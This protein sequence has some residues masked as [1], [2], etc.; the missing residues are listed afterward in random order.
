MSRDSRAL[1]FLH[2]FLGAKE[3]FDP[4]ISL[5][6]NRFECIAFDLSEVKNKISSFEQKPHCIGYS[7]GGR[8][9][10]QIQECFDTL[11]LLSAH[12]GLHSD[13]EKKER[14]IEEEKW[15]KLLETLSFDDFLAKWYAQ[16]LFDSLVQ[17]KELFEEMLMRRKN[18]NPKKLMQLYKEMRL[19]LSTRQERFSEKIHWICGEEDWKY[20]ALYATI[21]HKTHIVPHAG[22]AVH[23]ENPAH[24]A[25][26]ILE[27]FD[28]NS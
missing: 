2:G 21:A 10:L 8:I 19:S 6:R 22:H 23:L 24:C 14:A 16:P 4:L 9:A 7:M 18:Q 26:I 28:A 27:Y 5:L 12:P 11:F 20:R 3:D 1:I 17:K 25:K 15:L 13:E